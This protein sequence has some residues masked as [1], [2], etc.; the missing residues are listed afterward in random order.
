MI[1]TLAAVTVALLLAGSSVEDPHK[2]AEEA[3]A[4]MDEQ[5]AFEAMRK[6]EVALEYLPEDG[7]LLELA[8]V[9]CV[10]L[11]RWDDAYWYAT[12]ALDHADGSKA[13]LKRLNGILER[14]VVR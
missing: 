9:A 4:L 5:R 14:K 13:S 11:D 6:L 2:L 12:L 7:A 1:R 8:A 10:E 3:R